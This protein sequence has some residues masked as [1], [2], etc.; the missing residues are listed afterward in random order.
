MIQKV[1]PTGK[2]KSS[3][4]EKKLAM[5]ELQSIHVNIQELIK[6][7][8]IGINNVWIQNL[9]SLIQ[10]YNMNSTVFPEP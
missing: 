10:S 6:D 7:L 1:F 4:R 5:D 3:N 9:I 8:K 2:K